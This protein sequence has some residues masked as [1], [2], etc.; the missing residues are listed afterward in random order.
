V[1]VPVLA[2]GC[3]D[4][5]CRRLDC[6]QRHWW[7]WDQGAT[8]PRSTRARHWIYSPVPLNSRGLG[9]AKGNGPVGPVRV[10][11]FVPWRFQAELEE[12]YL[13]PVEE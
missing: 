1:V 2:L 13:T 12:L 11:A 6:P 8:G 7:N 10:R 3:G 4:A 5:R 9:I